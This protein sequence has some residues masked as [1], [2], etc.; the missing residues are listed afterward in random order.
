MAFEAF[1]L[2]LHTDGVNALNFDFEQAFNGFFYFRLAGINRDPECHLI[3]VATARGFLSNQRPENYGLPARLDVL[4]HV[5]RASNC[6]TAFFV[7][8]SISRRRIS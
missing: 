2:A 4:T 6:S 1:D 5:R 8:K 7:N 3:I